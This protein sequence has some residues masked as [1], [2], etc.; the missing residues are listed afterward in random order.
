MLTNSIQKPIKD[1]RNS[2]ESSLTLETGGDWQLPEEAVSSQKP[3]KKEQIP[4]NCPVVSQS[5]SSLLT[6]MTT[7]KFKIH[8]AQTL[9]RSR[10]P[11]P[12]QSTNEFLSQPNLGL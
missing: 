5:A 2:L 12:P 10:A 11:Q 4:K 8:Q 3:L 9:L 6:T 1:V 7:L